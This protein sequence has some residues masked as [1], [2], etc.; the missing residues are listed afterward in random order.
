MRMLEWEKRRFG[1]R[2]QG[3]NFF[4]KDRH[5]KNVFWIKESS[6]HI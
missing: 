5:L 6:T 2:K 3:D 4:L 1:Q